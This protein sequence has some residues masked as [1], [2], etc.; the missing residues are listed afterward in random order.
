MNRFPRWV[1]GLGLAAALG[2]GSLVVVG[3]ASASTGS[4]SPPS[5]TGS[6]V[7]GFLSDLASHLGISRSTLETAIKQTESDQVQQR[8]TAGKITAATAQKLDQRIQKS[9]GILLPRRAGRPGM[10]QP[11]NLM[12]AASTYLGIPV[13]QIRADLRGGQSLNAIAA[14]Q[15]GKSASGLAAALEAAAQSHLQKQLTAG[16][17]TA[18]GEQRRLSRFDA[19]LPKLL[20]RAGGPAAPARPSLPKILPVVSRYLGISVAQIRADLRGGQSLNA[21]AAAQS[22]KSASGLAAALEAAAESHLQKQLT[23]GK[24]TAAQEGQRLARLESRLPKILAH[25]SA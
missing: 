1:L 9:S 22:G 13:S 5:S 24:I 17:I 6:A 18:A 4:G 25:V 7:G 12:Q 19:M 2:A 20:A 15:P 10:P 14:A 21:I 3:M 23:A 16:K 11:V 8:L